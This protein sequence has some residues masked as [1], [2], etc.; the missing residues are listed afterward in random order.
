MDKK[1]KMILAAM[2]K[3][4]GLSKAE[5]EAK[6][7][8]DENTDDVAFQA[9]VDEVLDVHAEAVKKKTGTDFGDGHKKGKSDTLT[10][11]ET[12]LRDKFPNVKSTAK[13]IA[14][15][16]Q[17]V[18]ETS[19]PNGDPAKLDDEAVKKHPLYLQ[20]EKDSQKAIEDA[21]KEGE[22]KL[23][24]VQDGLKKQG[25]Y[26]E[27]EKQAMAEFDALK[28]ILG[29]KPEAAAKRR[30]VFRKDLKN[31]PHEF[32]EKGNYIL[33]DPENKEKRKEDKFGKPAKLA[34]SVKELADDHG[35]EYQVATPRTSSGTG[36]PGDKADDKGEKDK[37]PKFKGTMPAKGDT[38]GY[39]A[40]LNDDTVD[41]DA[42]AEVVT[43]WG[44]LNKS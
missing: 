21:K 27:F 38:V 5:I 3:V 42:K 13:G 8:F 37:G 7:A 9:A 4:T 39:M 35:F 18:A 29:E 11:L 34:D 28:P 30:E 40:I 15:I 19:K 14:L 25:F 33:L 43:A 26:A 2:A 24:E 16:E 6:L 36:K 20:L 23:K 22:T 44:E 17:I 12:Q 31:I 1:L 32:D 10:D 41:D